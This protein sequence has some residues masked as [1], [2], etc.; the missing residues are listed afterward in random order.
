MIRSLTVVRLFSAGLQGWVEEVE[1]GV[2]NGWSRGACR[3]PGG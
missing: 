3:H 2:R 1:G